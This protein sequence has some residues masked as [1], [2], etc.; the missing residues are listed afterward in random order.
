[1]KLMGKFILFFLIFNSYIYSFPIV[2]TLK[3]FFPLKSFLSESSD[4]TIKT[5]VNK[6]CSKSSSS[7]I[8][9]YEKT[10]PNYFYSPPKG[11]NKIKDIIDKL[12]ED[13]ESD[14]D[15]DLEDYVNEK[16]KSLFI[17]IIIF[18]L[19][20]LLWIPY[21][22]MICCKRCLCFPER[23]YNHVK[24]FIFIC[25]GFLLAIIINNIVTFFEND[26]ITKG[27]FGT[28]CTIFKIVHHFFNGDDYKIKPYWYGMG[29][30]LDYINDVKNNIT[31]LISSYSSVE[32]DFNAAHELFQDFSDNIYSEY[33]KRNETLIPN[34]IPNI[35]NENFIRPE[36]FLSGYGPPENNET[37]LWG[38][39]NE[40]LYCES[41]VLDIVNIILSI[42][43]LEHQ[44]ETIIQELDEGIEKLYSIY[45]KIDKKINKFIKNTDNTLD[46][47]KKIARLI[48]NLISSLNLIMVAIVSASL[49]ILFFAKFG[50]GFLTLSSYFLYLFMVLTYLLG[51]L[52]VIVGLIVQDFSWGLT[53]FIHNIKEF[54]DDIVVNFADSCFNGDGTLDN[55]FPD[56][57]NKS[58]IENIFSLETVVRG[59][60]EDINNYN[61]ITIEN[62]NEIYNYIKEHP[63]LVIKALNT[64]LNNIQIYTNLEANNSLVN[65]ETP[66]YDRWEISREECS[67]SQY[68]EPNNIL[69]YSQNLCLVITEWNE[70]IIVK[71]Y[72]NILLTDSSINLSE[73]VK[74]YYNSLNNFYQDYNSMI[75]EIIEQNYNFNDSFK[76]ISDKYVDILYGVIDLLQ[77]FKDFFNDFVG[78]GSFFDILKCNYIKRDFNKIF[79]ELYTIFGKNFKIIGAL[80]LVISIIEFLFCIIVI[81][82]IT[83]KEEQKGK[84]EKTTESEELIEKGGQIN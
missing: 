64:S 21:T 44:N 65:E 3:R 52:F 8:K 31:S 46:N 71:R 75:N 12:F 5:E 17:I 68:L 39:N 55:L 66:V 41:S 1:M 37:I 70:E 54:D 76:N 81:F 56:S 28:G 79:E 24:I 22:C 18:I 4:S 16:L 83:K 25:F 45:N 32:K 20:L 53:E 15:E 23:A 82:V 49:S 60:I 84:E 58:I 72:E 6:M 35:E 43:S 13:I 50:K 47:V 80:F 40:L 62:A 59:N 26:K 57:F 51:G 14:V 33:E 11:N 30:I 78:E 19:L 67:D 77:P 36:P 48:L 27:V 2:K 38:I 61:S 10:S 73:I 63:K 29:S 34:P 9:F 69:N 42:I 74:N 7:L